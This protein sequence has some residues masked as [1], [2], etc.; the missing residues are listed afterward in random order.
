VVLLG[1][2]VLGGDE[3]EDGRQTLG[4][5]RLLVGDFVLLQ[6]VAHAVTVEALN[7]DPLFRGF[8][9]FLPTQHGLCVETEVQ[10]VN[11]DLGFPR[12]G[13]QD[14]R[15]EALGEL[16]HSQSVCDRTLS[17]QPRLQLVYALDE[18]FHPG[19]QRLQTQEGKFRP[20]WG[21][22]VYNEAVKHFIE[23][24]G[25]E[26]DS[27]DSVTQLEQSFFH[28]NKEFREFLNLV[29]QEGS[30]NTNHSIVASLLHR[31]ARFSPFQNFWQRVHLPLNHFQH[32]LLGI[33]P[34]LFLTV[35]VHDAHD[36]G[37]LAQTGVALEGDVSIAVHAKD[38]RWVLVRE[39]FDI[40]D[41]LR[42]VVLLLDLG[43]LV[44]TALREPERT[45]V[46]AFLGH[47]QLQSALEY[48]EVQFFSDPP[49]LGDF[50]NHVLDGVLGDV[51]SVAQVAQRVQTRCQVAFIEVIHF[52]E[53]QRALLFSF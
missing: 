25:H 44:D 39:R 32:H 5:T 20:I 35:I 49:A 22:F 46:S 13:L 10:S 47:K 24:V 7:Q 53:P 15:Q 33:A 51:L 52:V 12:L 17:G 19:A 29:K 36:L 6:V 30:V 48:A 8:L 40:L 27:F 2:G 21:H 34:V 45:A 23:V 18:V 1:F 28:F 41:P 43:D 38:L 31:F 16:V 26:C 3:V 37:A 11:F 14:S 42:E 50:P 4:H 9:E